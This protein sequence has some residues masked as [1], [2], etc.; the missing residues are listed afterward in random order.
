VQ[1][2]TEACLVYEVKEKIKLSIQTILR[3]L[4]YI[5]CPLPHPFSFFEDGSEN[6]HPRTIYAILGIMVIGKYCQRTVTRISYLRWLFANCDVVIEQV[7]D[8]LSSSIRYLSPGTQN[9][10]VLFLEELIN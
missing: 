1:R 4:C 10:L 8:V 2:H 7:L 6:F 3:N 9:D 5:M